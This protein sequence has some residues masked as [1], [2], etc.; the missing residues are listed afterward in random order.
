MKLH[1]WDAPLS[2]ITATHN[3]RRLNTRSHGAAPS[4]ALT[5]DPGV[6]RAP[7]EVQQGHSQVEAVSL[8]MLGLDSC[9]RHGLSCSRHGRTGVT[10]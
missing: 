7:S 3:E 6:D 5:A 4:A 8:P 2:S 1:G 9:S 10:G